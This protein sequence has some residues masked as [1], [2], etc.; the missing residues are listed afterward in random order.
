M[1]SS[2]QGR[3]WGWVRACAPKDP[4]RRSEKSNSGVEPPRSLPTLPLPFR[5]GNRVSYFNNPAL[6][7]QVAVARNPSGVGTRGRHTSPGG[8]AVAETAQSGWEK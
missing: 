1:L 4:R 5:K 2:L 6:R 7:Y 3:G 8:C